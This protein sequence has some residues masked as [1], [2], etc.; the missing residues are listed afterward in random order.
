MN[1]R[2]VIPFP[3]RWDAL[4][5]ILPST[6]GKKV[7][8]FLACAQAD[9]LILWCAKEAARRQSPMRH[10][11]ARIDYLAVQM[12]LLMGLRNE[13]M[14]TLDVDDLDL[15]RDAQ[16]LIHGKGGQERYVPI[17]CRVR[18]GG[19]PED[20]LVQQLRDWIGDRADGPLLYSIRGR[21]MSPRTLYWRI[22]RAGRL[23]GI[24]RHV[25]PHLL[26]HSFATHLLQAGADI[27]EVQELLGHK[28]LSSTQIYLHCCTTKL[29][30]AVERL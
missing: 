21:R 3:T 28:H 12:G 5:P 25:H 29:R 24:V 9:K 20:S 7:P 11:A 26:R 1:P 19:G 17:K 14:C 8:K 6:R 23:S 10:H 16:A 2:S 13:E 22:C 4:P 18:K 15:G 30:R 27:R